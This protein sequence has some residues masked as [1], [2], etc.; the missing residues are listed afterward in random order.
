MI[1]NLLINFV[2]LLLGAIF[3][4]FPNAEIADIPYIGDTLVTILV[5]MVTKWN[6]I[7]D[8]IPYFVYPYHVFLYVILPFEI[9]MLVFKSLF[10]HRMP[11][12]NTA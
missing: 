9:S 10:G 6:A 7:L 1:I 5:S 11:T 2:L 4:L 3:T 12:Q 8:T